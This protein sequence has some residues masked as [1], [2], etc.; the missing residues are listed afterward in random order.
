M[1]PID[2]HMCAHGMRSSDSQGDGFA[3][4]PTPVITNSSALTAHLDGRCVGGHRHLHAEAGSSQPAS[5][6]TKELCDRILDGLEIDMVMK[7]KLLL[8]AELDQVRH[9]DMCDASHNANFF[10]NCV[11]GRT[12][13]A[14]DPERVQ[15]A[16]AEEMNT[17]AEMGVYE[18]VSEQ[19]F[20]AD[21]HDLGGLRQRHSRS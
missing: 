8:V 17:F 21:P 12:G 10:V 14:L 7:K 4:R 13:L 1:Q 20:Q 19:E 2:F 11:D 3:S 5:H 16:R 6:Y 9:A 18:H 15:Q